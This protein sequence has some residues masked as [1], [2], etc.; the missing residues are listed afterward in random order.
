MQMQHSYNQDYVGNDLLIKR[1]P[2]CTV[3]KLRLTK[4]NMYTG[5]SVLYTIIINTFCHLSIHHSNNREFQIQFN[6]QW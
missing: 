6:N 4:I 3:R 2:Y 5:L 1:L